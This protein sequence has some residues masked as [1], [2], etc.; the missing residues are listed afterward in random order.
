L[1]R[2]IDKNEKKGKDI[3][4][5]PW[6]KDERAIKGLIDDKKY[7]SNAEAARDLVSIGLEALRR[8]EMGLSQLS[9]AD[10]ITSI[11][12]GVNQLLQVVIALSKNQEESSG[13]LDALFK[14][15]QDVLAEAFGASR[16]LLAKA[17]EIRDHKGEREVWMKHAVEV[18]AGC[19]EETSQPPAK[20][21]AQV[22]QIARP[23][24]VAAAG[25]SGAAS[26]AEDDDDL[27]FDPPP[28][29]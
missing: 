27:E 21:P 26:E 17:N 20:P 9:T 6:L 1:S 23:R 10:Q 7:R 3:S 18:A 22:I 29:V 19:V 15:N 24:A 12:H 2:R 14:L 5:E 4:F 13:S 8:E 11:F 16:L 25:I 28:A